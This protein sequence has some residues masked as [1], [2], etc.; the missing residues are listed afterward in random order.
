MMERRMMGNYHVRCEVG[1]NLEMVS[2]DYLS[3][4]DGNAAS[5]AK[6]QKG[7]AIKK[8]DL[9]ELDIAKQDIIK[10]CSQKVRAGM[11]KE[12]LYNIISEY[13]NGNRQPNTIPDVETAKTIMAKLKELK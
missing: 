6:Q 8:T 11:D 5:G 12:L 10:L 4:Y 2:K 1:E 9:S 13:N 7:K 3:L